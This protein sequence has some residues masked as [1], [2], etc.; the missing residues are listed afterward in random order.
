MRAAALARSVRAAPESAVHAIACRALI[1]CDA[2]ADARR[3]LDAADAAARRAGATA[4]RARIAA[5][6]AELE[7]RAGSLAIAEAH[8][9]R[10]GEPALAWLALTL[11]ERGQ[12]ERAADVL[13]TAPVDAGANSAALRFARGR[14]RIAQRDSDGGLADL[15]AVGALL[16]R[17]RVAGPAVLPWRAEAAL[18]HVARGEDADAGRMAREECRRRAAQSGRDALTPAEVRV[19]DLAARGLANREIA[20]ALF[21]TVKTIETELG[22]AYAKL[23]IRSRRELPSVLGS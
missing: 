7:L 23:G 12:L 6:R 19:A 17:E 1:W 4:L 21:L 22:H 8:A 11:L 13:A 18:A 9:R 3:R 5:L 14:V 20:Q 16:A 2:L 15:L 10:G